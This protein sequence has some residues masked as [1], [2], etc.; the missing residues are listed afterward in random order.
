M[1]NLTRHHSPS[2]FLSRAGPWLA[3]F[4]AEH[5]VILDVASRLADQPESVVADAYLATVETSGGVTG[6]AVMWPKRELILAKA[7]VEAV[8][9][10]ADDLAR[11]ALPVAGVIGPAD[12]SD[13]FADD[14]EANNAARRRKA[15][16]M[17]ILQCKRVALPKPAPGHVRLAAGDDVGLLAEWRQCFQNAVGYF[18]GVDHTEAVREHT[19]ASEL[20]IWDER[21]P[22]SMACFRR[23]TPHGARVIMVFTPPTLRGRGYATSCVAAVT[24]RLLE[25]D[26]DFVCLYADRANP[27]AGGMYRRIGYRPIAECRLWRFGERDAGG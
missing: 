18:D 22:A 11:S 16:T 19:A 6:A 12:V 21:G 3:K 9:P 24:T 20:Y 26:S 17:D 14:W 5:S 10:L 2:E 1:L 7:P 4:E 23:A 25:A 15:V 13:R 27:T 8:R